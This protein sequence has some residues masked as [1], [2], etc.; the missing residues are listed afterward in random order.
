MWTLSDWKR[1]QATSRYF[2]HIVKWPISTTFRLI[3]PVCLIFTLWSYLWIKHIM[4][5]FFPSFLLPLSAVSL[6]SSAVALLLT[7]RTNQSLARLAEAREGLGTLVA[8]SRD[9]A[10]ILNAYL[11]KS[12]AVRGCRPLSILGWVLKSQLR[13]EP[14]LDVTEAMLSSEE[15]EYVQGQRKKWTGLLRIIRTFV[16]EKAQDGTLNNMAHGAILDQISYLNMSIGRCERIFS[17]PT[18]P[19]YT[20]HTSRVLVL[21]LILLPLGL[22]KVTLPV[23]LVAQFLTSYV[24]LGIDEIGVELEQPF[25]IIPLNSLCMAIM[26]DCFDEVGEGRMALPT[27]PTTTTP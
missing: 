1:H 14:C 27:S 4:P 10:A 20:R 18:P 13:G 23:A 16:A 12:S 8:H 15:S 9:T 24:L 26:R 11:P 22:S 5:N 3:S 7:L 21:W 2:R 25:Q 17:S 6:T 19:T